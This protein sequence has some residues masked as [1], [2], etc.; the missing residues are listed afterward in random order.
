MN[1]V[2]L[3]SEFLPL[4]GGIG[5]YAAEMARSAT[6]L[7]ASVT[8]YA[9]DY[10]AGASAFGQEDFG[11][12]V[13][14][15]SGGRHSMKSMPSKLR[16]ARSL[17]DNHPPDLI[18]AVDWPFFLPIALCCREFRRVYTIHGTEVIETSS[19]YK[20]S[21]IALARAYSG[22]VEIIANSKFTRELFYAHFPRVPVEKVRVELLGV[23][24]FWFGECASLQETRRVLNI[25]E[26]QIVILT[27]A[28]LTQRKGHLDILAGLSN[29]PERL[30]SQL[31]YLI[32]GPPYDIKYESKLKEAAAQTGCDVR[33]LGE[34][35]AAELRALYRAADIFC[36]TGS[37]MEGGQVEGFG[38]VYLEAGAQSL[39][40]IAGN[41]GGMPEAVIDGVS[42][43][44]VES[45]NSAEIASAILRLSESRD[46]R[47]SLAQGALSRAR[48]LTWERCAA[49]TYRL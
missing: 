35:P 40:S 22:Q 11:Y 25:A 33:F 36:L 38:L 2:I 10:R 14:R 27:V 48:N 29:L 6:R 34:R 43:V 18:H 16:V 3:T 24:E 42:G 41:R 31:C 46:F 39:P 23:S 19:F 1:L 15:F 7:G 44:V 26:D 28:R 30:K 37:G 20:R 17:T 8:L 4:R 9:P 45:G 21:A 12:R 47:A 49:A 5:T 32:V 13:I